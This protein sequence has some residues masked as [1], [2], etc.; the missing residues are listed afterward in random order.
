M[1]ERKLIYIISFAL[2]LLFV[3]AC[4]ISFDA[5]GDQDEAINL[6]MTRQSLQLTQ[7]ALSSS[8]DNVV[9][10]VQPVDEQDDSASEEEVDETPCHRSRIA[11]ETIS[12]GT[13]FAPGVSFEKTW[14]L[15]NT[16][17]C[18]WTTSYYFKFV[19]GDRMDGA[20]S[21]A[22]SS[23]IEPNEQITFKLDLKAPNDPGDYTG[24][25][26]LFA[27]D[28]EGMGRYWVKITV[29]G[30]AAPP[31]DPFAGTSVFTDLSNLD[32]VDCNP[33]YVHPVQISIKTNGPGTVT[34]S[35]E[36]SDSG[37]GP[38][39]DMQFDA[40]GTKVLDSTWEFNHLGSFDFWLKVDI[41]SPNH[42][43]F[44]PFNFWVDCDP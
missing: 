16:G 36:R 24:I 31:S 7:E 14:T 6:Q 44:G 10:S 33:P 19:E 40:A 27:A 43:I 17:D 13:E 25:W 18:D 4:G 32:G 11:G 5:G 2:M 12:D 15:R 41:E 39:K 1:R 28:G 38:S 35:I 34:V 23:V 22:V 42:Q 8:Q 29:P 21:L 20:S 9:A 37:V 30:A 3:L 26:Q